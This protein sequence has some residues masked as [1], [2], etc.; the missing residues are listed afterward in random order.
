MCVQRRRPAAR[1]VV[2][3]GLCSPPAT[4]ALCVVRSE[5]VSIG[6]LGHKERFT[7]WVVRGLEQVL[8]KATHP[9][10]ARTSIAMPLT[11]S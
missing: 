6:F 2:V 9:P 11:F 4:E 7:V 5:G 8:G 1:P 3:R 10:Q